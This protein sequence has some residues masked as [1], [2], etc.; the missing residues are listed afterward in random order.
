MLRCQHVTQLI[1]KG[2]GVFT[3]IKVS[4]LFTPL[5]P[6]ASESMKHLVLRSKLLAGQQRPLGHAL[7]GAQRSARLGAQ[8]PRSTQHLLRAN[9]H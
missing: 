3:S 9:L 7:E 2:L 5:P 4:I 1:L 8:E 6:T